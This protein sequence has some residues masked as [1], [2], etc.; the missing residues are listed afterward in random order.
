MRK[1]T[2]CLLNDKDFTAAGKRITNVANGTDNND[3]ANVQQLYDLKQFTVSEL[4]KVNFILR[5]HI[6][7]LYN[8]LRESKP[9]SSEDDK[10]SLWTHAS[11]LI[12]FHEN[13]RV[14]DWR[15]AYE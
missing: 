9:Y 8:K 14:K 7:V 11:A 2:V 12:K 4:Y 3:I 10:E 6:D 1:N 15:T 5:Y 13:D